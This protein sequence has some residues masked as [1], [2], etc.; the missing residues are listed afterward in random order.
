MRD[1]GHELLRRGHDVRVITATPGLPLVDG[2]WVSRLETRLL[3]RWGTVFRREALHALE[4]VL[5]DG[6]FDIVHGHSL[7][8]P[9]AMMAMWA[10]R[11]RGIA[12]VLQSHSILDG[13][14]IALF[15]A[16]DRRLGWSSW[17]TE[18]AAVSSLTVD[19]TACA[20]RREV[21]LLRNCVD[22]ASWQCPPRVGPVRQI[23]SVLRL[24]SRKAPH[25]LLS[26]IP[27]IL[28]ALPPSERPRFVIAGD[29][30]ERA[31]LQAHIK[32]A[33]LSDHVELTG[34]LAP[35]A[36]R[37]LLAESQLFVHPT[38]QEAF[39]IVL[40]EARAAGLPVVAMRPSGARDIVSEGE[41]GFL[42]ADLGQLSQRIV[43]LIGDADLRQAM[44]RHAGKG[45][46][47]WSLSSVADDHLALYDRA[48]G[49][50]QRSR[51]TG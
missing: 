5:T 6:N 42:A 33:H 29:G 2:M 1:V 9:L 40:L 13:T 12:C 49:S 46:A 20:T 39:G 45:L 8:S 24:A 22:L 18:L 36:L 17:P 34:F 51:M 32:R 28:E 3:P 48:L 15:R 10:A 37:R 35:P 4:E 23:A 27:C 11:R 21:S 31:G 26:V 14:G 19:E 30:P 50:L 7:W 43:A 44:S 38:V 25:D 16:L 47:P 41:T